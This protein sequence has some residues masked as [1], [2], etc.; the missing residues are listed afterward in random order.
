MAHEWYVQ[1]GGKQYGPMPSANLKKL[2]TDG[3]I[4]PAT[5]VRMGESGSWVPA[6]KVQGLFAAARARPT[7][8]PDTSSQR[9]AVPPPAPPSTPEPPRAVDPPRTVEPPPIADPLA[10][11]LHAVAASPV[12]NNGMAPPPW[13]KPTAPLATHGSGAVAKILGAMAMIFAAVA[14]TT[15]WLPMLGGVIGW[16]A[17][18][19]GGLGLVIGIAGLVTATMANSS[20]G[21]V[22]SIIGG[23]G[24]AVGLVLT[25]VLGVTFGLFGGRAEPAPIVAALPVAPPVVQQPPPVVEPEPEAPPSR[26]GP[27][28]QSPSNKGQS[29]RALPKSESSKCGWRARTCRASRGPSRSPC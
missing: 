7:A 11:P 27:M 20:S 3:K 24:S 12:S 1:H 23:G 21:L 5:Q 10:A 14:V 8:A 26:H 19:F 6:A 28:R 22:L 17:I 29:R 13:A 25:V 16:T 2:A 15:C 4:T 18:G 9:I